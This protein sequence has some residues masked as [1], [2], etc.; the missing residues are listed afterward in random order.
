MYVCMCVCQYGNIVGLR[1]ALIC[2]TI[3]SILYL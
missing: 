1:K 3:Y 2:L